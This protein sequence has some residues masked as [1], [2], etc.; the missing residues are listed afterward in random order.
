MAMSQSFTLRP[1]TVIQLPGGLLVTTVDAY[2]CEVDDHIISLELVLKDSKERVDIFHTTYELDGVWTDLA[3]FDIDIVFKYL[4]FAHDHGP[5]NIGV[6]CR[7][8]ALHAVKCTPST[9]LTLG[10]SD[11]LL[12]KMRS[13]EELKGRRLCLV[14]LDRPKP[15]S[16]AACLAAVYTVSA[17]F[18]TSRS[19]T[20]GQTDQVHTRS[21]WL[22]DGSRRRSYP[23][24]QVW[25]SWVS[26]TQA[27]G[28][29][30]GTC[31]F[32]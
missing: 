30:A 29:R 8:R 24:S 16:N 23:A 2:P 3:V 9:E 5:F 13:A 27:R 4:S 14:T 1:N 20:S 12:M 11:Q 19:F 25:S 21:S 28:Y 6:V 15:K 31:P 22:T 26:V 17:F 7:F 10:L 32:R 18:F